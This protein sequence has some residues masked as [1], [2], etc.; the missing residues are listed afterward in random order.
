MSEAGFPA[1]SQ[2]L[3]RLPAAVIRLVDGRVVW[4]NAAALTLTQ[5]E[6]DAMLASMLMD[7]VE[8]LR[9]AAEQVCRDG[10]LSD[11][12]VEIRSRNGPPRQIFS[13]AMASDGAGGALAVLTDVSELTRLDHAA[14][15]VSD[16]IYTTDRNLVV[17]WMP[18]R[19]AEGMGITPEMFQGVNVYDLV[20]PDD[21]PRARSLLERSVVMPGNQY[22]MKLR[23]VH[24]VQLDTYYWVLVHAMW[25]PDDD[26]LGG[27]LVRIDS[28]G[29]DEAFDAIVAEEP[30][31]TTLRDA[32]PQGFMNVN[33]NGE[34]VLCNP[35]ARTILNQVSG[36]NDELNWRD[37]LRPE[38]RLVVDDL[39]AN[40]G[41]AILQ[42][43][44]EVGFTG[45]GL[46]VWVRLEVMPYYGPSG[47]VA[48]VFVS[49]LNITTEYETRLELAAAKE[50]LWHLAHHDALTGL[51]NRVPFF[52]RL[53]DA[54]A[55]AGSQRR[56]RD[57]GPA[58]P[59]AVM[60]LDLDGFKEVN[61]RLGHRVGDHALVEVAARLRHSVR[62]H[63]MLCR[64]GGDEFLVLCEGFSSD[65]LDALAARIVESFDE[66]FRIDGMTC[67][68]G[69]SIG[70]ATAADDETD[71]DVLVQ[72]ADQAM[73]CAKSAGGRRAVRV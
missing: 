33:L 20:H 54:L 27:L 72:R 66:E 26:A 59:P 6:P 52:K 9:A 35:R 13:A 7:D 30:G 29:I 56:R 37:L 31:T 38:D 58:K 21:V 61:D 44:V 40:A 22:T 36:G 1:M 23:V 73:Y 62:E 68:L 14:G 12:T 70:I 32:A 71:A 43:P 24:P 69:V 48:G 49:L 55:G 63:D 47:D 46:T 64:Y 25:L 51:Q 16:G 2:V 5:L 42:P 15:A 10:P 8:R 67:S 65:E 45:A 17:Q 28:G 53:A 39:L 11:V 57:D 60:V 34:L 50:Q 18:R 41:R 19:C 3:E 4:A